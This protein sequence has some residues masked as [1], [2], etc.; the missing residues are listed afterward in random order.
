MTYQED[1]EIVIGRYHHEHHRWL[2]SDE[3]PECEKWRRKITE[4]A[5]DIRNPK[6]KPR[7]QPSIAVQ[8]GNAIGALGRAAHAAVSGQPVL[9]PPEVRDKRWA[10]CM[11]CVNLVNDRCRLCGCFFAKKIQLA[12]E[13]CPMSPPKW[14]AYHGESKHES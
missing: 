1:L 12:T 14:T 9:V 10:Q 6:P 7:L 5:S 13:S 2:V 4:M 3:N 11:T 8:A